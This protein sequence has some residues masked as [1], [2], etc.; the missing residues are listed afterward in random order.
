MKKPEIED[1]NDHLNGVE[2]DFSNEAYNLAMKIKTTS[3]KTYAIIA[4]KKK[5]IDLPYD[6][7]QIYNLSRIKFI[8]AMHIAMILYKI[9][10]EI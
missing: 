6:L 10:G 4:K 8:L 7:E 2:T 9:S 1:I 5:K 3:P